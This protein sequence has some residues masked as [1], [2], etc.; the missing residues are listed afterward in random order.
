MN[1][2]TETAMCMTYRGKKTIKVG[3]GV[4]IQWN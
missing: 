3:E 4:G 2:G 1:L